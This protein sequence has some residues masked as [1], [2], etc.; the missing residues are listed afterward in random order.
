MCVAGPRLC[1]TGQQDARWPD[2]VSDGDNLMTTV[3]PDGL[4]VGLASFAGDAAALM[5]V[6]WLFPLVILAVGVPIGL[7]VRLLLAIVE[8]W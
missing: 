8:R 4:R 2:S 6:V 5:A 1:E 7:V 3:A